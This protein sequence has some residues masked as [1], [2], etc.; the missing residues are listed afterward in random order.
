MN[1]KLHMDTRAVDAVAPSIDPAKDALL[2]DK[3]TEETRIGIGYVN[4]LTMNNKMLFGKYNERPLKDT[5]TNKMLTSF[6]KHGIQW[7]KEETALN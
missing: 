5:E 4:V 3:A 1:R 7:N 2:L 6:S